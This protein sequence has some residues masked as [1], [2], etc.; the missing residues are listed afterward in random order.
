MVSEPLFCRLGL[1]PEDGEQLEARARRDIE[2]ARKN[3]RPD[4]MR[5]PPENPGLNVDGDLEDGVKTVNGCH[6]GSIKTPL[7]IRERLGA[8]GR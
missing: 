2:Q 1:V 7:E 5:V 3:A 4:I 8:A 6:E